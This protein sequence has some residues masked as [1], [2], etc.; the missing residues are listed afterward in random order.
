MKRSRERILITHTGSLPRPRRS[1]HTCLYQ[2]SGANSLTRRSLPTASEKVPLRL[3]VSSS[4]VA[5][6]QRR[7]GQQGWLLDLC[8]RPFGRL[9]RRDHAARSYR[10]RGLCRIREETC[11][12]YTSRGNE[13]PGLCWPSGVSG[14]GHAPKRSR[15]FQNRAPRR[16]ADGR[17]LE[18]SITWSDFFISQKRS[19]SQPRGVS[20][21]L[22]RDDEGEIRCYSSGRIFASD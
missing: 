10:S 8:Q 11:C 21:S 22:S 13:T 12:Q 14:H 7:R 17:T 6:I 2:K 16:A 18:Y 9:R 4:S 20:E 3:L 15:Q 19:L 5:L 1:H